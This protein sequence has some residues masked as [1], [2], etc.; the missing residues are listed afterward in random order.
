MC[1]PNAGF[2]VMD[3][4]G[5]TLR[6][7]HWHHRAPKAVQWRAIWLASYNIA[8]VTIPRSAAE[9]LE[10][11]PL[12]RFSTADYLHMIQT[13][14]LG[15]GEHVELIAGMIVNMPPAGSRHHHFLKRLNQLFAPIWS[16]GH[17]WIQ[18]TLTVAEGEVYD[19]DFMF[20]R[21]R[22]NGYK[23]ELPGPQDVLLL[24]EAADSSLRRDRQIKLPVYASAGVRDYWIA[25]LERETLMIH[26]EPESGAYRVTET[27]QGDEVVSPLAAPELS[28]RVRQA[29]E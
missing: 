14:V 6:M 22:A 29:F 28:F 21:L 8:M 17:V 13:G 9:L 19:P 11:L 7:N 12:R 25:D 24:V 20:L 2:V 23:H 27:R 15:P 4:V 1:H 5:A 10:V 3:A 16:K 26:R 18:G